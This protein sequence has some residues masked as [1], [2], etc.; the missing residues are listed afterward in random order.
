MIILLCSAQLSAQTLHTKKQRLIPKYEEAKSLVE[1]GNLYDSESL[2]KEILEKDESF[3]EAVL[4]LHEVYIKRDLQDEASALIDQYRS[5]LDTVFLNRVQLIQANYAFQMGEYEKAKARLDQVTGSVYQVSDE[6]VSFLQASIDFALAQ[7]QEDR[8]IDFEKLPYPVNDFEQQYFPSITSAGELVYTVRSQLG[9]GDEDI[10][11]T[12]L[13]EGNWAEPKSISGKINTERNEGTATISADG[14]TLVFTSCNRP[15]NIGSCD[16]YIAYREDEEWTAPELLNEG[17]NSPEWDSQPSLTANGQQLY[18]VSMRPGG[19]GKQDIWMSQRVAG[20]WTKAI[21]LGAAVNTPEDDCSPF[22]YLDGKTLIYASKGK[23][24]M[25]GYDLFK[26]TLNKKN[27][28]EPVN[29]GYPINN[30]FDQVGYCISL[31]R[32]AYFSSSDVSG[33]IFLKRF[34]VPAM[35]LPEVEFQPLY[36]GIV[37]DDRTEAP[38]QAEVTVL[39]ADDSLKLN[40]SGQGTFEWQKDDFEFISLRKTGYRREVVDQRSFEQD[41]VIRMKPFVPGQNLLSEPIRFEFDSAKPFKWESQS[42]TKLV[43]L[44]KDYPELVIEIQGHTD[45]LGD[46]EYNRNL[47]RVRAK[48]VYEIL[49]NEGISAERMQYIGL[50]E[51]QPL[52]K[53]ENAEDL[54]RRVEVILKSIRK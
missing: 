33:K 2:L 25:G 5:E 34:R 7:T 20:Q 54:N 37:I 31:D 48:E 27:W 53:A 10:Y 43:Q 21:N 52:R 1:I 32:W 18:F 17:V 23:V 39:T 8:K 40:S 50:G 3:D 36:K 38:L 19:V 49:L 13:R 15:G 11:T 30:A 44:L 9:R 28:S 26:T 6:R 22:I 46:A 14:K 24:G 41:S 29:L 45:N 12:E 47:S 51:S 4:L 35:I 42:L 16:L